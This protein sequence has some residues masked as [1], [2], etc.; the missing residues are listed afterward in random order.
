LLAGSTAD[1]QTDDAR[2]NARWASYSAG[3]YQPLTTPIDWY[4]PTEAVAGAPIPFATRSAAD[5]RLSPTAIAAAAAWAQSQNST[6]LIIARDGH[7]VF[8]RYWQGT[9][10]DTR[11]NPQS[12]SKTVLALLVGTAVARGEIRSVDDPVSTSIREWRADSRGRITLRVL[13]HMASGLEQGDNGFGYQVTLDNPIVRHSFGS[14]L[15]RLPLS[16]RRTADAGTRFDYNNQASQLIGIIL[17]R[18]TRQRYAQLL[19]ARLWAPLGLADAAM[20]LDR[21]GGMPHTSCCIFSRPIDW[22]RVGE[23]FINNGRNHAGEQIVPAQWLADMATPSPAYHGYGYQLWIGDQN[24]GGER[25]PGVPLIPWQSEPFAQPVLLLHGHGGQRVYILPAQRLVIVRAA[26]D[27]PS[28]WDD[29]VL[30][31][32]LARGVMP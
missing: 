32:L 4:D 23:L 13:L 12:M 17:Q 30:P 10:R 7:I 11:F 1:A 8:E 31:N 14:D 29:A 20:P 24:I 18:A 15:T 6:A 16:L 9:G 2:L 27:W 22:V 5:A 21:P 26:R 28:A 3:G 19:S 25:P